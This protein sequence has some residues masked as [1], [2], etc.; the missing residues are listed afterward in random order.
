MASRASG[1]TGVP[2][3]ADAPTEVRAQQ[4][5]NR[6]RMR[7]FSAA[8]L[9]LAMPVP[10]ESEP[11]GQLL[12]RIVGGAVEALDAGAGKLVVV[13]EAPWKDLVPGDPT[14]AG[15]V[16]VRHTGQFARERLRPNDDV[17]H[18]LRTGQPVRIEDTA[19]PSEFGPFPIALARGVRAFAVTP[20]RAGG[21][22][23]GA[24]VVDFPRPGPLPDEELEV[25]NLFATHAAAALERIRL[26]ATERQLDQAHAQARVQTEMNTALREAAEQRDCALAQAREA[27]HLRDRFLTLAAHE[28]RTPVTSVRGYGQILLRQLNRT[29]T[30]DPQKARRGL[31]II[32]HQTDRL[33]RLIAQLLDF[34]RLQ[35]QELTLVRRRVD[36]IP[37]VHRL[38]ERTRELLALAG[39]S[40][41]VDSADSS[42]RAASAAGT[43]AAGDTLQTIR[44][45]APAEAWATVD[46]ERVEQMLSCM[47]D[48]AV[49]YSP[50][51]RGVDVDV[52]LE[53]EGQEWLRIA[54]R[55]RGMGVPDTLRE[56]IFQPFFQT[57]GAWSAGGMGLGLYLSRTL[58]ELHGGTLTL[59]SPPDGGSRF[60]LRL[61]VAASRSARQL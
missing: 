54:V 51:S 1:A 11:I 59:D 35:N 8:A 26:Q 19:A 21:H 27:L 22:V 34:A 45:T 6:R 40:N 46:P 30:L 48:N 2:T 4:D 60:T 28:L 47:L 12:G 44:V 39:P 9:A 55:D 57:Q 56:Q 16:T 29:G 32:D 41:E 24:L 49:R 3:S 5:A 17:R 15:H 33:T 18:V 58:A 37:L 43:S 14:T 7:A 52:A 23:L 61:P 13:D 42:G 31:E 38:I 20:L 10:P 50:G 36:V 53:G 25:L